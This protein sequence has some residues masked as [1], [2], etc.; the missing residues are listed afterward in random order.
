MMAFD[1]PGYGSAS[2]PLFYVRGHGV[3]LTTF[4][5]GIYIVALV[6]CSLLIAAGQ[7]RILALF[8]FDSILVG[9]RGEVWRLVTY[10]L[11]HSPSIWVLVNMYFLYSFG[12]EAEKFLGLKAFAWLYATLLVLPVLLLTAGEFLGFHTGTMGTGALHAGV[13]ALFAFVYPGVRFALIPVTALGW[14]FI[15]LAL[16]T[17]MA[18]AGRDLASIFLLWSSVGIA[19]AGVRAAG[20]AGG[21]PFLERLQ[22]SLSRRR[23][24]TTVRGGNSLVKPRA[25]PR[26]VVEAGVG[27]NASVGS[28]APTSPSG[29]DVHDSIDPLL[30][31]IA[32]HGLGSL[33]QSEK[34]ALE[35]AR[36]SLLRKDRRG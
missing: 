7:E 3:Y 19:Y 11:L 18:L 2:Q 23:A 36:A 34:A 21:L 16:D 8:A 12:R 17:L 15:L 32:K 27:A 35:R 29:R 14:L 28:T 30:D 31:K 24:P 10:P 20:A 9:R 22:N 1:S 13:F 25:R 26:R 4:L 5:V 6:G 33:S